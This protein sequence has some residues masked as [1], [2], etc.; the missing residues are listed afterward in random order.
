MD[1]APLEC[2]GSKDDRENF[3]QSVGV[4]VIKGCWVDDGVNK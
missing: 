3:S 1:R 2:H 4:S